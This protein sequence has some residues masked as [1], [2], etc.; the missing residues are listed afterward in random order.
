M[1]PSPPSAFYSMYLPTMPKRRLAIA[2]SV[3][4]FS[5]LIFA[6]S[7]HAA[8]ADEPKM[9]PSFDKCIDASSGVTLNMLNC[10]A[11]ESDYQDKR[12][13]R[14]YKK[15]MRASSKAEQVKLRANEIK[16][17]TGRDTRCAPDV[18]GGT[19]ATLNSQSCYLEETARQ[20]N[21]LEA[22]GKHNG[23]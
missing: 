17:L 7:A 19:S 2:A 12:L 9:R 13:N 15:L 14:A 22:K 3:S 1:R 20:A 6:S 11:A 4:I 10:I 16:W 23:R 21:Y 8:P 5:Y 18:D